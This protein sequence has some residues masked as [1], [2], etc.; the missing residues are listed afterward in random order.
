MRATANF[1]IEVDVG[2]TATV[3]HVRRIYRQMYLNS[4]IYSPGDEPVPV[5][6]ITHELFFRNKKHRH[7]EIMCQRL[8]GI[9]TRPR[10]GRVTI[11]K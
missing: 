7:H 5:V 11:P 10:F 3:G 2:G 6:L 1:S 8:F 4:G 9:V